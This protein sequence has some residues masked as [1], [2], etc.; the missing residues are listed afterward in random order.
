MRRRVALLGSVAIHAVCAVALVA[1]RSTDSERDDAGRAAI[2]LVDRDAVDI[3]DLVEISDSGGGGGSPKRT[4]IVDE[5]PRASTAAPARTLLARVERPTR[6]AVDGI[7]RAERSLA[8]SL[9]D[10]STSSQDASSDEASAG[11]GGDGGTGGGRGGGHGRGIG[12]GVGL[13]DVAAVG[14]RL[15]A[16]PAAPKA[17]KARPAKLI[18]PTRERDASE[19]ELFVAR[20]TIDTDGDVVGARLLSGALHKSSDATTMIF[21]FRYLPALDDDGR[22]VQSTLEQPFL[23]Q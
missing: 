23:V 19:G 14:E 8:D 3:V 21:M 18:Y 11:A 22:P 2:E 17:S 10:L 1:V 16:P 9:A 20:V 13:G 6:R 7:V 4:G 15:P 12:R 5:K